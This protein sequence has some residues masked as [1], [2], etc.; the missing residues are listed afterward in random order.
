[1]KVEFEPDGVNPRFVLRAGLVCIAVVASCCGVA[2]LVLGWSSPEP[3]LAARHQARVRPPP[4]EVN[5][6][7]ADLL[8]GK[9]PAALDPARGRLRSFGWSDRSARLVHVPID[10]AFQLYLGGARA[11]TAPAGAEAKP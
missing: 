10:R 4:T 8:D 7:E 1:M 6:I 11:A 3:A 9:G 5:Q 2:W